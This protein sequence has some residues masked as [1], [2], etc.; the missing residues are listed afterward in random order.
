MFSA[1]A[2]ITPAIRVVALPQVTRLTIGARLAS[3]R[4]PATISE[5]IT[6]D[7]EELRKYY[8]EIVNNKGD[9]DH[10]DRYGNQFR[11]ELARH[12]V[13]EELLVYPALEKYLGDAGKAQADRDREQHH[14]IKVLLKDFQDLNAVDDAFVPKLEEIWTELEHHIEEEESRDLP[15]LERALNSRPVRGSSDWSSESLARKFERTKAFVPSRSHPAAG[16]NPY[17]ESAVGML[18]APIDRIADLFRKFPDDITDPKARRKDAIDRGV[19]DHDVYARDVPGR[20]DGVVG[21]DRI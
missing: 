17:F 19:D 6:R 1:R 14:K 8:G 11:W 5:A 3:T 16:E 18:A 9:F 4:A 10:Q 21:K 7:H 2:F 12:S 13:A 15:D 20:D